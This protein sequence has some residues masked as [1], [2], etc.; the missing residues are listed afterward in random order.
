MELRPQSL[1]VA[2]QCV[3]AQVRLLDEQLQN[4]QTPD[5]EELEQLLLSFD[6]A[7][8]DLKNAYEDALQRY[9]GLPSY[10]SLVART[11]T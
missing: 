10:E 7:A 4:D 5:P 2:I 11:G 1:M 9:G 8:D 6:L 3:A